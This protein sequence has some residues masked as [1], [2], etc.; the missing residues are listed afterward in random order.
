MDRFHLY[1]VSY[2]RYPDPKITLKN[3][4]NGIHKF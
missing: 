3:I 2:N 4:E 1:A